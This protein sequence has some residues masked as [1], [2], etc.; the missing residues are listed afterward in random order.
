MVLSV[1]FASLKYLIGILKSTRSIWCMYVYGA[2][3]VAGIKIFMA[4]LGLY[5]TFLTGQYEQTSNFLMMG[6]NTIVPPFLSF[7]GIVSLE[8]AF[9]MMFIN[10]IVGSLTATFKFGRSIL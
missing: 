6:L 5:G 8:E 9:K 4:G 1:L 3:I 7:Q 2:G 10:F